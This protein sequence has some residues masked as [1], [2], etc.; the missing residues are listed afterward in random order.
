MNKMEKR[1]MEN[2][3]IENRYLREMLK[4]SRRMNRVENHLKIR[5]EADK[6]F[7]DAIREV[8]N[9]NGISDKTR[10]VE[11]VAQRM[12]CCELLFNNTLLSY[13]V[14][15]SILGG[16]DHSS[17]AHYRKRAVDFAND[18]IYTR[19][20]MYIISEIKRKFSGK[21]IE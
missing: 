2:L 20:K 14:I 21:F 8:I 17:I 15:G 11:K 13:E 12:A 9:D 7:I 18:E 6:G 19:N 3:K 4:E 10:K 16:K 5:D 1:E